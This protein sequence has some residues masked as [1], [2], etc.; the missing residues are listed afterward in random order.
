MTGYIGIGQIKQYL[1]SRVL[2]IWYKYSIR[3]KNS[4]MLVIQ[5]TWDTILTFLILQFKIKSGIWK[6]Y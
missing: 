5:L 6:K 1:K 3:T 4:S 2:R